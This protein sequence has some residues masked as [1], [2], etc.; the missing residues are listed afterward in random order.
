MTKVHQFTIGDIQCAV[1]LEGEAAT[2]SAD[3]AG[4]YPGVS[5]AQIE[6]ALGDQ[7]PTGSINVLYFNSGG[8]HVLADV[9]F[10]VSA[11][12]QMG[13][14]EAGLAEMGLST[15]DVDIVFLTHFH[16]DHVAGLY[17]SDG[18]PSFPNAHYRAAQAEWDE[19]LAKWSASGDPAHK[20]YLEQFSSLEDRFEFL[21]DGD[22]LVE[23]VS[24]VHMPGHTLGHSGLL[25]ESG[26][27]RL[28]H[29]V[30]LLHQPFQFARTEWHFI[31]DSDGDMAVD[32]RRR[33]L[34]RCA[35]EGLLTLFYHLEFPGL[36]T[37]RRSGDS[38]TWHPIE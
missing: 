13:Q 27:D 3:L 36:G 32:T 10:G 21:A 2:T 22:A 24:V 1:L 5:Q 4:R 37:V 28:L 14:V 26:G 16:G 17:E 35:D 20:T 12:P 29:V 6:S 25:L 9:G 33:T 18:A 31:F 30:D 38:F 34:G 11:R 8:K 15:G 23:G 19:W 7:K